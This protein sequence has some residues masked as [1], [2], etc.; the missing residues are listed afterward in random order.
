LKLLSETNIQLEQK[1]NQERSVY[2]Q[3]VMSDSLK[4]IYLESGGIP[5]KDEVKAADQAVKLLL[6]SEEF[7][8]DESYN[9][10]CKN[11]LP[12]TQKMELWLKQNPHF[13]MPSTNTITTPTIG[14]RTSIEPPKVDVMTRAAQFLSGGR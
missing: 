1:L 5:N 8:V 14:N 2:R 11:G 6:M 9:L 4:N 12:I 10:V 7:D 3:K 13:R